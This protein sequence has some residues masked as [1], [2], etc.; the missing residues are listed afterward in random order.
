MGSREVIV[1]NCSRTFTWRPMTQNLIYLCLPKGL[2][3]PMSTLDEWITACDK[4]L[5]PGI[6]KIFDTLEEGGNFYKSYAHA[7]DFSVR[8]SSETTDKSGVKWKYFLA[9]KKVASR[10]NVGTSKSY[11]LIKEWVG[12][13]DNIGC[14][15]QDLQNYSRDLKALIKDSDA[16]VFIDNF[17]RKCEMDN[18]FYYDYEVDDVG[19]LKYVFWADGICRKNY[20]LVGDVVSFDTTYSTNKYSMIFA[21]FTG[22]NHHRQSITFGAAFLT[23]E[24]ADSFVWLFETFLKAMGGHKPIVIITDQ[25]PT[26]KIAIKED[27]IEDFKLQ[28]NGWLIQMY[29][30]RRTK[31]ENGKAVFDILDNTMVNGNKVNKLREVVYHPSSNHIAQYW[32]KIFKS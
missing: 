17:R 22:V 18:S 23:N 31:E 19:R 13:Y 14:T 25:D 10:A 26:M 27:I 5:K 1:I 32:C 28:G 16:H 21:P 15:Q 3:N 6:G 11:Q 2:N 4:E 12:G 24:K 9:L 29:D 30:L 20:S 7:S 8:N